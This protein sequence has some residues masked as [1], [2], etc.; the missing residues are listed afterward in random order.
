[1]LCSPLLTCLLCITVQLSGGPKG[2]I[3]LCTVMHCRP[4]ADGLLAVGLEFA[5]MASKETV[6]LLLKDNT[7]EHARIRESVLR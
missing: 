3:L 2:V 7:A 4:L 6:E 1:M 5:E